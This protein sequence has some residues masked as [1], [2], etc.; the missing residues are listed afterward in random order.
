M[1]QAI[2]FLNSFYYLVTVAKPRKVL[3]EATKGRSSVHMPKGEYDTFCI[4]SCRENSSS[5]DGSMPV[6]GAVV[7]SLHT[8][9]SVL[10]PWYIETEST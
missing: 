10:L 7:I 8:S 2:L 6:E 3:T 4:I 1:F 9:S 5:R